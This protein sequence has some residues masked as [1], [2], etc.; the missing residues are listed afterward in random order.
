MRKENRSAA[1]TSK[2]SSIDQRAR[3]DLCSGRQEFFGGKQPATALRA[4]PQPRRGRDPL[5]NSARSVGSRKASWCRAKQID[6]R[7]FGVLACFDPQW[8]NLIFAVA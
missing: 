4:T 3:L 1:A 8:P 6:G 2:R 5:S 7:E